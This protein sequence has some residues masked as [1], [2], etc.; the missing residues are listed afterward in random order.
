MYLYFLYIFFFWLAV[1]NLVLPWVYRQQMLSVAEMG[2]LMGLKEAIL[3]LVLVFLSPRLFKK[4]WHLL[5][6]DK[7]GLTYISLLTLYLLCGSWVLGATADFSLRLI[8]MRGVA[9]LVLFYFWGRLS[10]FTLRE[11]RQFIGFIV[12]LQVV[13]ALFGIY[14][15]CFLPTSFWSDT[16]G[17]G[18]FMLDVKGLLENQNVVDGLP[19]NMFQFGVRRLLSSYGE[20]LAMGIACVFPLLLCLTVL[21]NGLAL[22][23][24]RSFWLLAATIIGAAL[25]LT[26]GRESIGAASIGILAVLW[27]CG[28]VRHGLMPLVLASAILLTLPQ[29]WQ[30]LTDTVTF[31]EASA[32]THLRFLYSGWKELPQM[33]VGKG[34]GEA[35]GWAFSLA[36]VQSDVGE[37]SYF[38]LMS[39]TG[40]ASVI[41]LI[42]F[43]FTLAKTVFHY[44]QKMP[45]ALVSAAFAATTAHILA[46][47][48]AG[49]FSP[50]LFGVIP[51]ASFFFFCGAS[52]TTMQRAESSVTT[53]AR[54]VLLLRMSA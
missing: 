48:L 49:I 52:L 13:V 41:L 7:F 27:M 16:V 44:F 23:V 2:I 18:T 5:A 39:Q 12:I 15:W 19:S 24:S 4:D 51:L 20:P 37:N 42:G 25:L 21:I 36:G 11:L 50:S 43:L 1:Q 47:S 6:A 46:R 38:E 31:R 26:I 30:Y 3:L 33:M 28:K 34:L 8:S 53:T 54:R 22:R 32:A 45:D 14:E 40:I 17:A 29:V 10:F 9:C 35:G